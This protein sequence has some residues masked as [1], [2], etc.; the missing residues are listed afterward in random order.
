MSEHEKKVTYG[1]STYYCDNVQQ[2][3]YHNFMAICDA[4][5][6]AKS[7]SMD[8]LLKIKETAQRIYNTW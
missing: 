1:G 2:Y 8:L 3:I 5:N 6:L 7:V 4:S